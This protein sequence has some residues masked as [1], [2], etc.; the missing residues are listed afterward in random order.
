MQTRRHSLPVAL[1]ACAI[2]ALPLLAQP[3]Q[4]NGPNR[5][6]ARAGE[7]AQ[8]PAQPPAGPIAPTDRIRLHKD[9]ITL[10]FVIDQPGSYVLTSDLMGVAGEDGII[11]A[12]SDV[13]I[14]LNGFTLRGVEGSRDGIRVEPNFASPVFRIVVHNGAVSNWGGYGMY[15]FHA[16]G[17]SVENMETSRNSSGMGLAPESLVR[18]SHAKEN[19]NFGIEL[20]D[21]STIE[22]CI[23]TRNGQIGMVIGSRCVAR[24][25]AARYNGDDGFRV[26]LATTLENCVS[27]DNGDDGFDLTALVIARGCVAT[28]NI[29]DGFQAFWGC[30]F[31]E[32]TSAVNFSH[33]LVADRDSIIENCRI[34]SNEGLGVTVR[35]RSAIRDSRIEGNGASVLPGEPSQISARLQCAI[36]RNE[37]YRVSAAGQGNAAPLVIQG[38]GGAFQSNQVFEGTIVTGAAAVTSNWL[39]VGATLTA[40]GP[41][42]APIVDSIADAGPHDNIR[43]PN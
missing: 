33:G 11:I 26:L 15:L 39:F 30:R 5:R 16:R 35:D 17:A 8:N 6:A 36:A 24:R 10:P 7:V 23:A 12:A 13:T 34:A 27:S 42:V 43:L 40:S 1:I 41:G 19:A 25:C 37:I 22:D 31:T 9:T 29:G 2:V 20:G 21:N 14:D 3:E 18:F 32:C 28:H 4:A 38:A